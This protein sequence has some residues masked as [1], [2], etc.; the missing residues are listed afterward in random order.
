VQLK[1]PNDLVANDGKLGGIL[2]ETQ[3]HR[4]GAI[5]V[6]TGIGINVE[7]GD[8]VNIDVEWSRQVADLSR[9]A[10]RIPPRDQLAARIVDALCATFVKYEAHGFASYAQ[11]WP[12]HDWLYGR[13]VMIDTPGEEV[14]GVGA[15]VAEDGALLVDTGSEALMRITSGSVRT[16][17]TR[18]DA[19]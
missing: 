7:L 15:G 5:T 10:D 13:E 14:S 1:W 6:V 4:S 3:P 12:E 2:T 9:I 16:A 17:V 18:G 11:A 19:A 8:E